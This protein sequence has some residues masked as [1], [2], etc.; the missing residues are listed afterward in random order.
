MHSI[1]RLGLWGLYF[2]KLWSNVMQQFK[3]ASRLHGHEVEVGIWHIL[4]HDHLQTIMIDEM[5]LKRDFVLLY[6]PE[7]ASHVSI[8]HHRGSFRSSDKL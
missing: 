8:N 3:A 6:C 5:S 2:Q 7:K 1:L 4:K